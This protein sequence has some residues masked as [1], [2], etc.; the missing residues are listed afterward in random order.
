[1]EIR[2]EIRA[3]YDIALECFQETPMILMLSIHPSRCKDLFSPH[4]I[5]FSGN[6]QGRDYVDMFGNTCTRII[7]PPGLLEIRNA[8]LIADS[9][10]PD[11]TAPDPRPIP[12][13]EFPHPPPVYLLR[14]PSCDTP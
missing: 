7:A 3:G 2:V 12:V 8:F 10:L 9:G 4:Q 11:A 14:T 5:R 13:V 6:V 1:M